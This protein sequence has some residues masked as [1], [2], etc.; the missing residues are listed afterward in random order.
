MKAARRARVRSVKRAKRRRNDRK[1]KARIQDFQG[2]L[3]CGLEGKDKDGKRK[4]EW[5]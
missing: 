3:G 1:D 5:K 2:S 4:K